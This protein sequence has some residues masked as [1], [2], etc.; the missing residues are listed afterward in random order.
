MPALASAG[1]AQPV[2]NPRGDRGGSAEHV[3]VFLT[4]HADLLS[5]SCFQLRCVVLLLRHELVAVLAKV[6]AILAQAEAL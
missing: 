5:R 3:G 2:A 1:K 4:A 6:C